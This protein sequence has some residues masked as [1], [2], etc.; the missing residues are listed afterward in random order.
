VFFGYACSVGSVASEVTKPAVSQ[1]ETLLI[2]SGPLPARAPPEKK[3]TVTKPSLELPKVPTSSLPEAPVTSASAAASSQPPPMKIVAPAPVPAPVPPPAVKPVEKSSTPLPKLTQPMPLA[4]RPPLVNV[5]RGVAAAFLEQD[6][7]EAETSS[8]TNSV[9]TSLG[10]STIGTTLTSSTALQAYTAAKK[11]EASRLATTTSATAVTKAPA[12]VPPP[13]TTAMT[14]KSSMPTMGDFVMGLSGMSFSDMVL[15][16]QT[17]KPISAL[18]FDRGDGK[19]LGLDRAKGRVS[20]GS[21]LSAA[22]MSYRK[23]PRT[24]TDS[25]GRKKLEIGRNVM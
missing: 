14:T 13:V 18:P 17:Q 21:R 4:T 23:R 16:A 9:K 8:T 12:P 7:D 1:T 19:G 11:V 6:D 2:G 22:K 3:T 10:V 5:S 15:A 20:D 24:P 25:R